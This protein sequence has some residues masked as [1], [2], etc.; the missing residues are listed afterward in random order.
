MP[1]FDPAQLSQLED[2]AGTHAHALLWIEGRNRTTD[3]I[4]GLGLWTGDDHRV[5]TIGGT[6]RTYYGAG[7]VIEIPPIRAAVGLEIQTH[8]IVLPPLRD[9]VR[10]ALRT[11]EPRGGRVELHVQTFDLGTLAP[12]GAPVRFL[13]GQVDTVHETIGANGDPSQVEVAIVS[14]ARRLTRGLPLFKSDAA[15]RLRDPAARGREYSDTATEW[16]LTWGEK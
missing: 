14:T 13:K 15:L 8:R 6:D 5:F 7:A 10:L 11:Y 3:A 4:E 16:T 9:E 1:D 12:I 2:R